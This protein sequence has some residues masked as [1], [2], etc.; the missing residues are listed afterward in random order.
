ML[1]LKQTRR[2]CL[3]GLLAAALAGC[4]SAAPPAPRSSA[5]ETPASSP[6]TRQAMQ[7]DMTA[8]PKGH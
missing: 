3:C 1:T 2:V 8:P 7:R 6:E 5:A 4:K